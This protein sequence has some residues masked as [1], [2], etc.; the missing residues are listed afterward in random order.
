M[1]YSKYRNTTPK[2]QKI[3]ISLNSKDI[4]LL[5][6]YAHSNK[7]TK[8]AAA[9]KILKDFLSQNVTPPENVAKNQLE[10]FVS[11]EMDLFDYTN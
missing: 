1:K 10:L 9:K 11:R 3:N 7:I 2:A 6:I 4:L 8:K 5:D